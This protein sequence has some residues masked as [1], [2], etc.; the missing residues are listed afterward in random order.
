MKERLPE[1]MVPSDIV[2]LERMPATPNGKL[3]RRALPA[4][5]EARQPEAA[6][7]YAAPRSPVEEVLAGIW[8]D[9]LKRGP[10]G[11]HAN[12]FDLGG[13]S[14]LATQ[15]VSRV[16]ELLGAEVPLRHVFEAP[17]VAAFAPIVEAAARAGQ[18][19]DAP[20]VLPVA[21]GGQLPL[22]FAQ[23]R[24]WFVDQLEGGQ[25]AYNIPVA[26]RLRGRLDVDALE[27]TLSEIGRRHEVLRTSFPVIDG[28]PVQAIAPPRPL[29]L[30]VVDLSAPPDGE[31]QEE[32]RRLAR[33]EA[34]TPFDLLQGPLL[35]VNLLRLSEEEH[36]LLFTMHH[37]VSDGW[38]MGVLMKEVS[39][40]YRAYSAGE[41]SP[42]A[43]LSVQYADFA[44]WQRE[45]LQGEAL[46][47]Q[48][49]YWRGQL[50]GAPPVLDLPTDRPRPVVQ[51]F[52]GALESVVLPEPLTAALRELA[53][54][55]GVTLF[56]ALVAGF[57]SLIHYYTGVEDMVVGTDVANRNRSETEG[58][59]GFFINQLVLRTDLSG[60]PSFREL[61]GRVRETTLGAYAHQDL[62]FDKLVETLNPGR[63]LSRT[64]LFQV[65][66]ILQNA[67]REVLEVPG[68]EMS[69][70][71]Q[72]AGF[73]RYDLAL[74]LTD[75]G[76]A[77]AGT[78]EYNTDL[79]DAST[80]KR[81]LRHFRTLL[82]EAVARPELALTQLPLLGEEERR[83]LLE[84]WNRT[85]AD[86]PR[87]LCVH[88]LFERQSALAPD[89]AA[90]ICDGQDLS[91]GE[92]DARSNQLARYLRGMGVGPEVRVGVCL[93]RSAELVV[94]LLAVMK[95]GG[96]YVP[97]DSSYPL[98]R[99]AVMLEDAQSP[100]LVTDEEG[101][102]SLPSQWGQVVCVDSDWDA[103][104]RESREAVEG[105]RLSK[106]NLAYV[107]YT[108]GSTGKPKG[109]AVTHRGLSNLVSWHRRAY[110]LTH[111]D[112]CSLVAGV[113]FDASAWELWPA[114][115]SGSSLL[116]PPREVL[117]S[118]GLLPW[119]CAEGVTVCF[120]PTPL[121]EAAMAATL[122]EVGN[123]RA[124]LTGGDRLRR[125]PAASPGFSLINHYGPTEG[126]VV[127][128]CGEVEF[129]AEGAPPIGRPISNTRAY[130]LDAGMRPVPMGVSGELYIGGDGLARGYLN[131]AALTA[132][133][134]VPD[135]FG[136]D[137][138]RL[139]RTG[140]VVRYL[141]GG[142]IE[143][144]GRADFQVKVRGFRIEL[145]E[146]EA[147]LQGHAGVRQ[148]AV[149]ARESN[150]GDTRLVAYVIAEGDGVSPAELRT[151]LKERL[152][153]YMVPSAFVTMD[154]MPLTANGKVDRRNLP[155][156]GKVNEE[157][158]GEAEGGRTPVEELLAGMW[159]QLLGAESVGVNKN[160]FELGGHS[161]LATQ[162]V[163]KIK[164]AFQ[165]ELPLRIIFEAPTVA[166]LAEAVEAARLEAAG[167]RIPP[168]E[169]VPRDAA[170]PLSSAQQRLW[171]MDQLEPGSAAYNSPCVMRL[172]GE[173]NF[174]ALEA[175][176]SEVYRRHEVLRT[177]YPTVDGHPV[178]SINPPEPLR[179]NV[180]D[181]SALPDAEREAEAHRLTVEEARRPF[182]LA[183]GPVLRVGLLK[184]ADD[185]HITHFMMHHIIADA[186]SLGVLV[187]EVGVLYDAFSKGEQSPLPEMKIQYADFAHWQQTRLQGEVLETE[188][189]YWKRQLG[190]ELPTL[191]LP[192]DRPRPVVPS[193]QGA[194]F[195]FVL[196]GDLASAVRR[197]SRQEAV[198][199]FMT[200]LAAFFTLL[201][202]YTKQQDIIVGTAH[203]NRSHAGT[204]GLIGF[205][206]NMLAMRTDLS[207]RPTFRELLAR[208]RETTL[209]AFAHQDVPFEKI[210]EELQCKRR[211]GQT[212]IFQVAFGVENARR[213]AYSAHDRE[214]ISVHELTM[215][216]VSFDLEVVRYDLTLWV[217]EGRD[218]MGGWWNYR[219][220]LFDPSTIERMHGHFEA[221]LRSIVERPDAPLDQLE[222]FTAVEREEQAARQKS[223]EES[224]HKRLMKI[225]PQAIRAAAADAGDAA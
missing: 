116:V 185:E 87:D 65:K 32:V 213:Q 178:Q 160:F 103:V 139:Y 122:E 225:K 15:L 108:S 134:F 64:P 132:E 24:L 193:Q 69:R 44:V 26:M 4:P 171:F 154:A 207:D 51:S 10:V 130:V 123:L 22:S 55:E 221:L 6:D 102:D 56:M 40:L 91:Y 138:G 78:A 28:R 140:D 84:D 201:H 23:Q 125:V 167:L 16:R 66:I 164:E 43:E 176:L 197:L 17:T 209:G 203:A 111:S 21:R 92:L 72:E 88:E 68:L 187:R 100:V 30:P 133:R 38:S 163:S 105:V 135:P 42:L 161:L 80:I 11:I 120:L 14:L 144:I 196:S 97:L 208:V 177:F 48:L 202:Q 220:S 142:D 62:P 79:F 39:A 194:R 189:R 95:A 52:N 104:A 128:T 137:G 49:D 205:F 118:E 41:S 85:E 57:K 117:L 29:T 215:S 106:D 63:D 89:S 179:L 27:R 94:A 158:S 81:M 2:L 37:I 191:E 119:L 90:V 168:I 204:E 101:L 5:D 169:P 173:L 13:H 148:C 77:L 99:L 112:R 127:A 67:P 182:D 147:A 75:G 153:E 172:K 109:V 18:G 25:S 199:P 96:V 157:P 121:A 152:P 73:S 174:A 45:W 47:K 113:G 219:T 222:M 214:P 166:A 110:S 46:E 188:L 146:I 159:A 19:L 198:T 71:A 31:R 34:R 93:P 223:L 170:L 211:L 35:R 82:A 156:P 162:L 59:I 136:G 200:L 83:E 180:T 53:R 1:Y 210:V 33:R 131:H 115:A 58:L 86:Y 186:W 50:A 150:D 155:E 224:K 218:R 190:G 74:H 36:V 216:P 54:R 20:A 217:R 126:T 129:G 124:M 184:L 145:G 183:R 165:V 76:D 8:S 181:I 61:L 195:P 107:I 192:T 175:T 149:V 3:D 151:H 212:P 114:L 9:V 7:E 143:F 98:E 12:F 70:V 60:A 141:R 206:V